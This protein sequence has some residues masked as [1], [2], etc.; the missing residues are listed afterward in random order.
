MYKSLQ[1]KSILFVCILSVAS[2]GSPISSPCT[3][4]L[5]VSGTP[6]TDE[7]FDA[8]V[9][10]AHSTLSVVR[11]ALLAP[12][13]TYRF[14]GLKV[15][16]IG[17]GTTEDMWTQPVDYYDGAFTIQMIEGVTIE[18]GIHPDSYVQVP[19]KRVLDWMIVEEDGNLIGGYTI[20]LSYEHMTPDEREEFLK[21]TGYKIN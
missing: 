12:R 11:Q 21:I 10:E 13:E 7:E 9:E 3:P 6:F 14:V 17:Q 2:C 20:R 5:S 1:L 8:A 18:R 16:F 15:R 4:D 19:L